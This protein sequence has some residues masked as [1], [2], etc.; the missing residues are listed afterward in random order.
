MK[1]TAYYN[2]AK[3]IGNNDDY[4]NWF[5]CNNLEG[6]ERQK[7]IDTYQEDAISS[8]IHNA[9][10]YVWMAEENTTDKEDNNLRVI[11]LLLLHEME[12]NP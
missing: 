6:D 10:R 3:K 1:R 2:L 5:C 12:V 11:A 9:N 8:K 4:W 7:F